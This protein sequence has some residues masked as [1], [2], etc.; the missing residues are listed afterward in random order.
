MVGADG[1]L[2]LQHQVQAV[3]EIGVQQVGGRHV[4][5]QPHVQPL[6][7]PRLHLGQRTADDPVAHQRLQVTAFEH[8]HE[9]GGRHQTALGVLPADQRLGPD[10]RA[11][12]QVDLGLVEQHKLPARIRLAQPLQLLAVGLHLPVVDGVEHHM[13]VLARFLGQVH[14]LVGVA[15]QGVGIGG[16]LRKQRQAQA[17][18]GVD[19]RTIH[20]H[21]GGDGGQRLAGQRVA[22]IGAVQ[23]GKQ[24]HKLIATQPRQRVIAAQHALEAFGHL[25]Q[26]L[27]AHG[28]AVRVIHRLETVQ[29][30]VGH[31]QSP[32]GALR[33]GQRLIQPVA[34]QAAVGQAGEDVVVGHLVQGRFMGLELA[35]VGG[36]THVML[37]L[38]G[39]IPDR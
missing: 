5:A 8:G 6:P 38:T 12:Q 14:G 21:R 10:H 9:L 2:V 22:G 20:Q 17:G 39:G 3:L 18:G 4:D 7:L 26:Q 25:H 16:I 11:I 30:D 36:H 32:P 29:I 35:D 28:V 19:L 33:P 1:G 31:G 23:I 15:Q 27:V 13:A 37:H 24:Q 34:Q